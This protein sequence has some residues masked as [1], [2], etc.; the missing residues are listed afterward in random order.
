[1]HA[2]HSSGSHFNTRRV[3]RHNKKAMFIYINFFS[4]K[5]RAHL[6]FPLINKVYCH[7]FFFFLFSV[8]YAYH[9]EMLFSG[10]RKINLNIY[11]L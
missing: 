7:S 3:I 11:P 9:A 2:Q 10:E 6:V 5:A 1:M 8:Y 4:T